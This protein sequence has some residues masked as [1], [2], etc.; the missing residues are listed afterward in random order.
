MSCFKWNPP[1]HS[2][3]I[4]YTGNDIKAKISG[5]N[6]KCRLHFRLKAYNI[7]FG[8]FLH[9]RRLSPEQRGKQRAGGP[10]SESVPEAERKKGETERNREKQRHSILPLCE[11]SST[12]VIGAAARGSARGTAEFIRGQSNLNIVSPSSAQAGKGRENGGQF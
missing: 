8:E 5:K 1:F 11:I 6:C 9:S 4:L 2:L 10:V 7:C 3:Y 12:A